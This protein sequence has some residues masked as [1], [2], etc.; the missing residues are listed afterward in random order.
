MLPLAMKERHLLKADVSLSFR[1]PSAK[2]F[3]CGE[4]ACRTQKRKAL[5]PDG[6]KAF[7]GGEGGIRINFNSEHHSKYRKTHSVKQLKSK[8]FR[9]PYINR[10]KL[11]KESILKEV[12]EVI[13]LPDFKGYL[14]DLGGPSANMYQ[15]KGKDEAICKK[16]K[17]P[18]CI[19]PKVC[20][21][22]NTDHRPLLD[23]YHAVDTLPGIKKS[24]DAP[25]QTHPMKQHGTRY[26]VR[27]SPLV[28]AEAR[29]P[30]NVPSSS[31]G[32]CG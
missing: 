9:P 26:I 15:M 3:S 10:G 11:S 31:F 7:C 13:Q 16:C 30:P 5:K 17:R 6:S 8:G 19:H 18:S 23:I 28:G 21:N 2:G 32:A 27:L 12:K 14:S 20:P 25:A 24:K 29:I 1:R 4:N 22:L